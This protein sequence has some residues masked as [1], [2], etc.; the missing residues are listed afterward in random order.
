M[1]AVD[2]TVQL[3]GAGLLAGVLGL[4]AVSAAV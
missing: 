4:A 1:F 3:S 2:W